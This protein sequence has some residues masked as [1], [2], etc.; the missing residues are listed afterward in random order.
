M[1]TA[2]EQGRDTR[3][4]LMDAAVAMIEERGWGA[5]TTRMVAERA[6]VRAG[7][8]HYH[9]RSVDDLLIDAAL[10]T[11]RGLVGSV[12]GAA[13][14]D[15]GAGIAAL[16]AS[17]AEFDHAAAENRVFS[18]ILLAAT[19]HDRLRVGL[20][21][22]LTEFRATLTEWLR[23]ETTVADPEATAVVLVAALDGLVLHRLIDPHIRALDTAGP[24][25]RLTGVQTVPALEAS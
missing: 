13:M 2:A 5:V 11:V 21:T 18:E 23:T 17:V 9:F 4:R 1:V 19:R 3:A 6:G 16:L 15:P 8:V 25:R 22:V 14:R 24:L 7:L 20:A 10:R 12:A